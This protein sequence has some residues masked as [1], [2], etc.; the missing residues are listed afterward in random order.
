MTMI[1]CV[2]AGMV[3][4]SSVPAGLNLCKAVGEH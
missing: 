4:E 2:R 1:V 3:G